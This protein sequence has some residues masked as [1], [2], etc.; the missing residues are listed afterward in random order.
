MSGYEFTFGKSPACVK[1]AQVFQER[2]LKTC[3]LRKASRLFQRFHDTVNSIHNMSASKKIKTY[4]LKLLYEDCTAYI[5]TAFFDKNDLIV[6]QLMKNVL[7]M[8]YAE[9]R[10]TIN[11]API[12]MDEFDPKTWVFRDEFSKNDFYFY[13]PMTD[14]EYFGPYRNKETATRLSL[15]YN[16][17]F[18]EKKL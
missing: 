10:R 11:E 12:V 16:N 14:K 2:P 1:L 18:W 7:M 4:L 9:A 8:Y 6:S 13:C 3:Q 17:L 5:E 15:K